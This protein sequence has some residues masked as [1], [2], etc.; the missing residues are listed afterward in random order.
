MLC[1]LKSVIKIDSEEQKD[2]KEIIYLDT[3]IVWR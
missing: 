2:M 3:K 1:N